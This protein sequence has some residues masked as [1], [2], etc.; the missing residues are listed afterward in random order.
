MPSHGLKLVM[1]KR[2][3]D[4]CFLWRTLFPVLPASSCFS[5]VN[6]RLDHLGSLIKYKWHNPSEMWIQAIRIRPEGREISRQSRWLWFEDL[7]L[8][9]AALEHH[10]HSVLLGASIL[11]SPA[12]MFRPT[13]ASLPPQSYWIRNFEVQH[14]TLISLLSVLMDIQNHILEWRT[15]WSLW[16]RSYSSAWDIGKVKHLL[17]SRNNIYASTSGNTL[18]VFTYCQIPLSM[19]NTNWQPECLV[20]TRIYP[21]SQIQVFER[22]PLLQTQGLTKSWYSDRSPAG[23]VLCNGV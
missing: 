22:D 10:S 9:K 14:L 1:L 6:L 3:L 19:A 11:A 2:R 23:Q 21:V 4:L 17:H 13:T 8:R 7:T 5:D 12:H 15:A 20:R 16:N 18:C